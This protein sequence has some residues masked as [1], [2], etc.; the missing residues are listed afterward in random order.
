MASELGMLVKFVLRPYQ[1]M[2]EGYMGYVKFLFHGTSSDGSGNNF[3][4]TSGRGSYNEW[5]ECVEW[6]ELSGGAIWKGTVNK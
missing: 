4:R 1:V 3:E 6:P 5:K 2:I